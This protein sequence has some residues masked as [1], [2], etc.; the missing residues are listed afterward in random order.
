MNIA[1]SSPADFSEAVNR[2]YTVTPISV[3]GYAATLRLHYLDPELNGNA[4]AATQLWRKDEAGWTMQGATNRNTTSKWVELGGVTQFS[5]WTIAAPPAPR[6]SLQFGAATYT[7]NENDASATITVTR[8]SGSGGAVSIQYATSNGSA[9]AG[10][11]Y[12]ST[13]GTLNFANGETSKTFEVGIINDSTEEPAE[14]INLVLSNPSGGATLGTPSAATLRIPANDGTQATISTELISAATNGEAGN[15]YSGGFV[16]GKTMISA[17]CRYV[18]FESSANDLVGGDTNNRTD[19][20]V[21][22]RRTGTTTLVSRASDGT[23]ADAQS[24]DGSISSDG[25]YVVFSSNATNLAPNDTNSRADIFVHDRQTSKTT[26]V[27]LSSAGAQ[28]S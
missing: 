13:Q 5:P 1:L 23:L 16:I 9:I 26:R 15:E 21:R 12:T 2:T 25:R 4:D 7:T 11:D 6:G 27:N 17:D 28:A 14:T 18:V 10:E 8:A 22:D 19:V 3:G 20:F 24:F